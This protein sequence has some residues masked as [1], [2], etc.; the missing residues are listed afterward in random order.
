MSGDR[1][2]TGKRDLLLQRMAQPGRIQ[3]YLTR[4]QAAH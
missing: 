4:V 3:R 2:R 1:E